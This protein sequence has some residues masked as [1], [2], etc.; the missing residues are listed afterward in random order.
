MNSEKTQPAQWQDNPGYAQAMYA[1]NNAK[2]VQSETV[3][4]WQWQDKFGFAQAVSV[5]HS[6]NTLYCSGQAAMD[7]EGRPVGGTMAEQ[8][9]MSLQNLEQVIKQA[10]YHPGNI[11][12]L[13]LYTTSVPDF[14]AAYE[15]LIAW[16]QLHKLTAASTL[17]QVEALA[18]PELTVEIEAIVVG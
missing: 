8:I 3:N 12:R 15:T 2:T 18:F 16:F 14:F 11:V 6:T 1:A 4:P 10:G 13:N 7:A 5:K 9:Q 17:V